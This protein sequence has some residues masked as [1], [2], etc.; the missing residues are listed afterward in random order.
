MEENFRSLG[1][2]SDFQQPDQGDVVPKAKTITTD[3]EDLKWFCEQE[4][5]QF[6]Y[7]YEIIYD[8]LMYNERR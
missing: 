6:N 1:V 4:L 3:S 7:I 5:G 2:F 8:Q